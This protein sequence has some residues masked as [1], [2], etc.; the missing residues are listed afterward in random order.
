LC[1]DLDMLDTGAKAP[2]FELQD[3]TGNTVRLSDLLKTGPVLVYFYPADF[4]PVCTKQ[5]C[6]FRDIYAQMKSAGVSVVGISPQGPASHARFR[7]Q[8]QLPFQLLSDPD[9]ATIKAWG[10]DGFFGMGVRRVTYLIG[11]DGTVQHSLVADLRVG[12]HE[13][14]AREAASGDSQA[15]TG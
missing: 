6:M 7:E 14:F 9:K 1:Q 2:D 3:D 5:A 15:T 10:A 8:Y 11:A 12:R 13:Q 4:T